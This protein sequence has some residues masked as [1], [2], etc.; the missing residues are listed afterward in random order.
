MGKQKNKAAYRGAILAGT[1]KRFAK[2]VKKIT[3]SSLSKVN[4]SCTYL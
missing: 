4:Y 1:P 2:G 3:S